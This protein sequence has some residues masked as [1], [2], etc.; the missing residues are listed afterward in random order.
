LARVEEKA[1]AD[2]TSQANHLNVPLMKTL[3]HD[4]SFLEESLKVTRFNMCY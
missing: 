2:G 3:S 1:R 4:M